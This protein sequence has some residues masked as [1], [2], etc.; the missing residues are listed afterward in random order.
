M[1]GNSSSGIV[2][3]PSAGTVVINIGDRQRGRVRSNNIIDVSNT[4]SEIRVALKKGLSVEV[5]NQA[6]HVISPFGLPGA[7]EK[8][9]NVIANHD[10]DGILNKVFFD[11]NSEKPNQGGK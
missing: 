9:F 11:L 8:I 10:L 2:E 1:V 6:A 7:S 5:Q 4:E 3:A